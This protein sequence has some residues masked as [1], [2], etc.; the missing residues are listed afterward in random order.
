MFNITSVPQP[1]LNNRT[2]SVLLG[3]AVG[4]SSAVNGMQAFRG[5]KVEYD[6]WAK[7]GGNG[8]TWDW[9]GLLP[10][11]R[12]GV[13]FVP[14]VDYLANDFNITWDLDAWGRD[15]DTNVFVTYPN[16]LAPG[17]SEESSST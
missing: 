5:S 12:R 4:G 10:Y 17:M 15:N 8:S 1:E 13:H 16:Y 11:F 9:D 2:V 7:L 3:K 14:P 6:L